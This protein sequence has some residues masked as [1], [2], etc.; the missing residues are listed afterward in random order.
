[1]PEYNNLLGVFGT[2]GTGK[3]YM[4]KWILKRYM[5][6]RKRDYFLIIDDDLENVKEYKKMGFKVEEINQNILNKNINFAQY[7]KTVKKL[8]LVDQGLI[9]GEVREFLNNLGYQIRQMKSTLLIIDEAHHFLKRGKYEPE[10]ILRYQRE[11]R[12]RGNDLIITTHRITDISTD[13]H[14]LLNSLIVFR[15]NNINAVKRVYHDFTEFDNYSDKLIDPELTRSQKNKAKKLIKRY[16]TKQLIK[17]LPDRW[18]LYS[19]PR[20]AVQEIS[21]SKGLKV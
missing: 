11:G 2:S 18:F 15:L 5:K 12:K 6:N 17:K 8:V 7:L 21:T 19:D 4:V 14:N 10:Q 13:F 20:H 9:K 3:S 16:D 1:M